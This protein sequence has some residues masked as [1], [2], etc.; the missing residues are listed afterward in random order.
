[1]RAGHAHTFT[2]PLRRAVRREIEIEDFRLLKRRLSVQHGLDQPVPSIALCLV[3]SPRQPA[4]D[5]QPI[6]GAGERHIEQTP[7]FRC[8]LYRLRGPQSDRCRVIIGFARRPHWPPVARL[9]PKQR[10]LGL[11]RAGAIGQK[12][13]RRLQAL[14]TVNGHNPHFVAPGGIAIALDFLIRQIKPVKEA[15]QARGVS[16]LEG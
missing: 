13:D 4:R 6:F 3:L 14:G 5:V 1:L 9:W 2:A 15:L 16:A 8:L 12:Y 10:F 7:I 11:R